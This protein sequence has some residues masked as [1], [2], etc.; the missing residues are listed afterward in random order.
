MGGWDD[1][2]VGGVNMGRGLMGF[3]GGVVWGGGGVLWGVLW[4]GVVCSPSG[5]VEQRSSWRT[6]RDRAALR[7]LPMVGEWGIMGGVG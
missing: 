6:W 5:L 7:L 3:Y 4:G 2:G 1:M